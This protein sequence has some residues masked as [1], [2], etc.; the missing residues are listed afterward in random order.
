LQVDDGV[1]PL[2]FDPLEEDE[3]GQDALFLCGWLKLVPDL[4]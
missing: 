1:P 3:F 4:L 2:A